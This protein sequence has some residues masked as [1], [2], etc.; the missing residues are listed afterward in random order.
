MPHV[1]RVGGVVSSQG[2]SYTP[3]IH[4]HET[5]EDNKSE[6]RRSRHMLVDVPPAIVQRCTRGVLANYASRKIQEDD[7]HGVAINEDAARTAKDILQM[8][9]LIEPDFIYLPSPC[10]G[11]HNRVKYT[12]EEFQA[13]AHLVDAARAR[14]A[15][16][17]LFVGGKKLTAEEV[18][19]LDDMREE[20]KATL[21][22]GVKAAVAALKAEAELAGELVQ[23]EDVKVDV[24]L[25]VLN[26]R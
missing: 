14:E 11:T 13:G 1:H 4:P 18:K 5:N 22:R 12:K 6:R 23:D 19:A 3:L 10:N 20:D 9:G 21:R 15:E 17:R 8:L 24:D 25:D 2:K 7:V 26:E 16:R